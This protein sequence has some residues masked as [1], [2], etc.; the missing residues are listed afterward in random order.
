MGAKFN[1]GIIGPGRIAEK[2]AQAVHEMDDTCIH[3]IASRSSPQPEELRQSFGAEVCYDSYEALAADKE[4]DAIYIATP[5]RFHHANAIVCLEAKKPVLCEKSITVNAKQAAS[6]F[7]ISQEKQVFL[8]EALW[9]R[10]LPIYASV[11]K[12]IDADEIGEIRHVYSTLGFVAERNTADR[13]LNIELAGG[14]VLDLGVYTSGLAQWA[15][16][17]NPEKIQAS[18]YLGKTGVDESIN[19][20]YAYK[21]GASAQFTCTFRFQPQNTLVIYGTKGRIVIGPV[22][23]DSVSA[24]LIKGRKKKKIKKPWKIN[25]FEY[26]IE[27]AMQAIRAGALDCPQMRQADTLGNMHSLD[28]I[29]EQIG[30]RYPFE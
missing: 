27:A 24:S 26:Q 19:V 22:F 4:I 17:Q 3:A 18:G 21:G 28:T 16:R 9:T 1:W 13:L 25:G 11:R 5:H 23:V 29:R 12:W 14:T 30:M 2:F 8:M 20:T 15:Y 6:L 7:S 10:F